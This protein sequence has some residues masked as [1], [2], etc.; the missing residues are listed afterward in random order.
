MNNQQPTRRTNPLIQRPTTSNSNLGN[1]ISGALQGMGMN[2]PIPSPPAWVQGIVNTPPTM[3][4]NNGGQHPLPMIPNYNQSQNMGGNRS[5]FQPG[6]PMYPPQQQQQQTMHPQYQQHQQ[7][8]YPFLPSNPFPQQQ[9][10]YP[11]QHQQQYSYPPSNAYGSTSTLPPLRM[12]AEGYTISSSYVTPTP[13][14]SVVPTSSSSSR[15]QHQ[16]STRGGHNNRGGKRGGGGGGV[17]STPREKAIPTPPTP[18][19]QQ[20]V[21]PPPPPPTSSKIKC[22][23]EGC[24]YEGNKRDLREHEEDRHL[25]FEKGREPKI[26]NGGGIKSLEG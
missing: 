24:T 11:L 8:H 26:W 1:A 10:F 21:Q 12:T 13:T 14:S 6:Y 19:I 18:K 3:M 25:I 7:Q 5:N 22:S 23:N 17:P 4:M 2:Y 15:P 20:T 16:L 9:Q